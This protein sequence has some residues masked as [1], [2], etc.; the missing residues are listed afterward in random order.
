MYHFRCIDPE[1]GVTI[2]Q[3]TVAFATYEAAS[4]AAARADR[5]TG[6][7]HVVCLSLDTTDPRN[8]LKQG[9][10]IA[11]KPAAPVAAP[12]AAPVA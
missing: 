9:Y 12:A 10:V 11:D 1:H 2:R 5:V 8:A 3:S 6:D 7:T 4:V